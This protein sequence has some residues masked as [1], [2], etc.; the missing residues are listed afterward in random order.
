MS[1]YSRRQFLYMGATTAA[2]AALVACQPKTVIVKETV[3]VEVEK[4]VVVEKEVVVEKTVEVEK[5]VVVEKT[6]EVEK[7]VTPTAL[8]SNF[9]E[10]PKIGE[11]VA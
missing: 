1:K 11:M 5:E 6:V 4:T 8:P 10:N 3:Q 9:G 2:G 7:V